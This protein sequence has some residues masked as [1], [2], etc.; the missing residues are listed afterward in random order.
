M[1]N[2]AFAGQAEQELATFAAVSGRVL[3]E[4]ETTALRDALNQSLQAI[5]AGVS[6]TQVQAGRLGAFER[7]R[8]RARHYLIV[9]PNHRALSTTSADV[10]LGGE[11]TILGSVLDDAFAPKPA[12]HQANGSWRNRR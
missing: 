12:V 4:P 7:R 8:R 11:A 1:A 2:R 5:V 3:P 6:L 9:A 10:G